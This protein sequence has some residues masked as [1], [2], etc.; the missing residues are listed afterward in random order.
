[1]C[2][3]LEVERRSRMRALCRLVSHMPS[4]NP[5]NV[6]QAAR[7]PA[8]Q[9]VAFSPSSSTHLTSASLRKRWFHQLLNPSLARSLGPI[10]PN[11]GPLSLDS[12]E[13]LTSK[14]TSLGSRAKP[15]RTDE[16]TRCKTE[17]AS[18]G[19][20]LAKRARQLFARVRAHLISLV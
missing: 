17:R 16:L 6:P 18:T 15:V 14:F 3:C 9:G 19:D 10:D 1:M 13:E 5:T 7:N 12:V 2:V 11:E 8:P 4:Y 20:A